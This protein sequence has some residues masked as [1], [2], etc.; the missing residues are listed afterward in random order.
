LELA[1]VYESYRLYSEALA[2]YTTTSVLTRSEKVMLGIAR[3]SLAVNRS[4]FGIPVLEQFLRES[5]SALVWNALAQLYA[6]TGDLSRAE[7]ALAKAIAADSQSDQWHNNL[8]FNL[9]QQNKVDAAEA[10]LRKALTL[11]SKSAMAHNNLGILLARRGDLNG[12]LQQFEQ[13]SDAATAHNNLAVVLMEMGKYEQS[14]EYL[15][16]ALALR[17]YFAPA[18]SNFKLVQERIRQQTEPQKL[19]NR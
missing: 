13:T 17:R 19:G 18:L 2:E 12:A 7:T 10:E 16:K 11:N 3:C 4:S 5:P 1:G 15:T 6:A 8:G 14:R 9:L